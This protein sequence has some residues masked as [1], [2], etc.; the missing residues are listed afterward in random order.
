MVCEDDMMVN[1]NGNGSLGTGNDKNGFDKTSNGD[2]H[3]N[4]DSDKENNK[5]RGNNSG[6]NED[7]NIINGR[8]YAKMITKDKGSVQWNLTVCGNFI[9][10]KMSVHELRY[11]LKRMWSKWGC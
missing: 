1:N 11:H 3:E 9:G 2:W 10:Y 4:N 8:T 6:S 5:Q 7:T